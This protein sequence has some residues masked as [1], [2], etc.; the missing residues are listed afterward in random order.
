MLLYVHHVPR[1]ASDKPTTILTVTNGDGASVTQSFT[2]KGQ[3]ATARIGPKTDP[4]PGGLG[5]CVTVSISVPPRAAE[6]WRLCCDDAGLTEGMELSHT[7]DAPVQGGTA[8]RFHP[9]DVSHFVRLNPCPDETPGTGTSANGTVG[10]GLKSMEKIRHNGHVRW[11]A[12]CR[13]H[14][15]T[16]HC[17]DIEYIQGKKRTTQAKRPGQQKFTDLFPPDK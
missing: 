4:V 11:G 3:E 17:R 5:Q 2:K 6:T 15:A 12:V 8:E 14:F 9:A 10:S 16:T 7:A 13:L 1:D